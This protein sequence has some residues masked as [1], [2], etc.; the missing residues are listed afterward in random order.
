MQLQPFVLGHSTFTD[1]LFVIAN[2][3]G[4]IGFIEVKRTSEHTDLTSETDTTAQ[5][6]REAQI[7]ICK[8][9][10][11]E[12]LPFILTNGSMWSYGVAAKHS[13]TK[14]TLRSVHNIHC[15]LATKNGWEKAMKYQ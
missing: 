15:E 3:G 1:F 4:P 8:D 9:H 13:F 7:L 5:A 14:I 10:G 12:S 2:G 6:L 11:V